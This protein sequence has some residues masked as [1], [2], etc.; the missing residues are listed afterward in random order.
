MPSCIHII[1]GRYANN[2]PTTPLLHKDPLLLT[3]LYKRFQNQD[4]DKHLRLHKTMQLLIH[5][6]NFVIIEQPVWVPSVAS[7]LVRRDVGP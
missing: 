1:I 6:L 7:M 3:R 2:L 5:A 4:T